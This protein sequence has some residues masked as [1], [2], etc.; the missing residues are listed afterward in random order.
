[1]YR[2]K[3]IIEPDFGCEGIPENEEICCETVLEDVDSGDIITVKVP[4]AQ[5]YEKC[6]TEG[7]FVEYKNGSLDKI[8]QYRFLQS[9]IFSGIKCCKTDIIGDKIYNLQKEKKFLKKVLTKE[10]K[11]G[12]ITKLSHGTADEKSLKRA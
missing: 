1:M 8:K 9:V 11:G 2:V 10:E 12:I 6:I 3:E 4:D 7:V 5:L